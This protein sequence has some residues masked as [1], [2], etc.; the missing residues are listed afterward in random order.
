MSQSVGELFINLGIKG[1]DVAMKSLGSIKDA[2]SDMSAQGI[3]AKASILGAIYA[4]EQWTGQ[5]AQYGNSLEQFAMLT[6]ESVKRQQQLAEAIR[7]TTHAT[8]EASTGEAQNF[9]K[10]FLSKSADWSMSGSVH[11]KFAQQFAGIA[12]YDVNNKDPFEFF[13]ALQRFWAEKNSGLSIAQKLNITEGMGVSAGINN[14]AKGFKGD[15][16]GITAHIQSDAMIKE[17]SRIQGKWSDFWTTLDD[18]R[19]R[20]VAKWSG[21]VLEFLNK[22]LKTFDDALK[23]VDKTLTSISA[24]GF[25]STLKSEDDSMLS[26]KEKEYRKQH[27]VGSFFSS[28]GPSLWSQGMDFLKGPGSISGLKDYIMPK[29]SDSHNKPTE[30]KSAPHINVNIHQNGVKDTHAS[31][32]MHRQEVARAYYSIA[33]LGQVA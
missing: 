17:L 21:P 26:P 5:S 31:V 25:L 9:I 8:R 27:P 20:Y 18:I 22:E 14:T 13:R 12:R 2:L 10:T 28:K 30:K 4:L 1:G 15:I 11:G 6:G 24:K 33:T 32:D 3:A 19:N 29:P 16:S 23:M 7:E